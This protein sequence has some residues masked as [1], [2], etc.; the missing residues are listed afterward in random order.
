MTDELPLMPTSAPTVF[1]DRTTTRALFE[2]VLAQLAEMVDVPDQQLG[3]ATPC[4]AY[5]VGDLRRHVLAW[6]QFFAAALNDPDG[7]TSRVD[8]ESW[9]LPAGEDPAGVV[10]RAAA[11]IDDAIDAGVAARTVVMSQAR[12]AGDGVLAMALGEYLVHGWDLAASTGRSWSPAGDASD[13]AHAF[14]ESMVVPEYRGEDSGFF[15]AE[16][17]AP[18][19]APPFVRLLCFTGRDPNW[20][21]RP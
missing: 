17:P 14:L 19:S 4:R 5:T 15:G 2:P 10:E 7:R 6:L 13:A 3:L 16:I 20:T 1:Q 21:P 18:A 9:S 11:G 8:P 12:M